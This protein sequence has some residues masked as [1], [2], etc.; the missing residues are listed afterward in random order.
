MGFRMAGRISG[1]ARTRTQAVLSL[2]IFLGLGAVGTLA[3]WSDNASATSGVFSTG[4]I[5]MKLDGSRPTHRFA[6]L[7]KTSMLRGNSVAAMLPVQNTGTTNFSYVAKVITTGDSS[8]ANSLT[9]AVRNGGSSNGATC[10][11]GTPISSTTLSTKAPVDLVPARTLASKAQ[12]TLCFQITLSPSAP[13]DTRM[14]SLSATFQFTATAPPA[15]AG[16]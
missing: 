3:S 2:G 13:D 7:E 8:L 6:A 9:V 16:S 11:G 5:E 1:H 14:K 12:D 15:S 4:T 10:A